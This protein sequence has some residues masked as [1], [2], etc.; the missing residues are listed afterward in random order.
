MAAIV[1][2]PWVQQ[3]EEYAFVGREWDRSAAV[4]GAWFDS[5]LADRM[6]EMWP[7]W[8]RHT[9]GRW[10]GKP[11]HLTKWQACIV[12]LLFGWKLEDGFRLYRRLLLWIA[13]KNGKSEFL[14][15]L[16]LAFFLVDGEFGGQAYAFASSEAQARIVFE[17]AKTMTTLSPDLMR[18]ITVGADTLFVQS[19]RAKFVPLSGKAVGKH[20][21][22]ASV[23]VGDEMHE[24]RDGE[25]L[26][27][28]HQST[29][30]RDQPIELLASTA[31][32]KGRGY[33]EI[34]FDESRRI[35]RAEGGADAVSTVDT[36][37]VIFAAEP[38][39]DWQDEAVWYKANP[40]LGV[41][42]TLRFL[43]DECAKAKDSPRL[44]A[45]FKRYYLNQWIGTA[46][47]WIPLDRWDAGAPDKQRWKVIE[48]QM[49]AR[50]DRTCF[51]GLDLSS[52]SD[53][54]ALVWIFPP[55]EGDERW[56]V[57]PRLWVPADNIEL[58]A[59]RDRV[60]YDTWAKIG[61]IRTTDG[62]S[63]D[64][65]TIRAQVLADGEVFDVRKL[66]VDRLFQGHETGV[67]LAEQGLPVEFF[68]QG[69]VSMSQPSKDFERLALSSLLDAGGHP[70]MR[71]QVDHVAYVQD[72]A[73]N[74]KPSKKKAAEKIDGIVALI[75]ALG[76]AFQ[77]GGG[78]S[79][80]ESHGIRMI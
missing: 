13:R 80:Y 16:A 67:A 22:S 6:V 56:V 23:A 50:T 37:V 51:G 24:W 68:G 39:D 36:L 64:Y 4:P 34:L 55:V 18:E 25:L 10:G 65:P 59:R 73:G 11:F 40:N 46:D 60:A 62:N 48:E 53:L 7:K 79:V 69:F 8:F 45:D 66:A 31:G 71:W 77:P 19:L 15:S 9:E 76:M 35:E 41:S 49:L 14:A 75:M 1:R 43:R 26:N 17:K 2:P 44:E 12:R 72:D 32:L 33:G 5:A 42:P 47:R 27:T 29:S 74:I 70:C 58:R 20:G 61:A 54:T 21:L 3:A 57:L 52:T 30:A 63:V 28:L 38:D 78:P